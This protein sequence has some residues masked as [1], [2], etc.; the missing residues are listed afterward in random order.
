MKYRLYLIILNHV[1]FM[2]DMLFFLQMFTKQCAV[3][4]YFSVLAY[5]V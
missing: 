1:V 5:L 2:R 4:F 3:F